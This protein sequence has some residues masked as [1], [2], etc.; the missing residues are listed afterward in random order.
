MR[1]MVVMGTRPEA[2]K[3][4]PVIA[5][6]Q[7]TTPAFQT[8]VVIT[9]QHERMLDQV[10]EVFAVRP[11]YDLRLMRNNQTLTEVAWKLLRRLD[12]ILVEVQPDL[13]LVQGDTITACLAGLASYYRRTPV[14]HVEAGLR[15]GDPYNP[16]PEEVNR[17]L[18]GVLASLHFAP[19]P[20]AVATLKGEG[21][22]EE[23][24]HLTGNTVVD[25]LL[26]ILTQKP[27]P[28]N[29]DD[30]GL[31]G[32]VLLVTAHRRENFGEPLR[33]ICQALHVLV[34][35]NPDVEVVF[36][37]H[38]NPNV[39]EIV[40]AVLGGKTRIHLLQPL[41]YVSFVHYMS[42]STLILTDS[43]GIQEEAPCL[44]K[45]VLILRHHTERPEVLEAG[46]GEL[47]GT[48][49]TTIVR[50]AQRLLDDPEKYGQMAK[51][52]NPFGDGRASERIVKVLLEHEIE[53]PSR[54]G[55]GLTT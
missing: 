42:R 21:V 47:V 7:H 18:L 40:F 52:T 3:L 1:V 37:V 54:S 50:A 35:R 2:I 23:R 12:P 39:R 31:R 53:R 6:L 45:P 38:L 26:T 20:R 44:G 33:A 4:C 14:A 13:V 15:T 17:R 28:K 19:T 25:A 55:H 10:L 27:P 32:R 22:P 5:R 29:L 11:D 24:I 8:T 36:P 46:V 30:L 49:T 34:D 43:G 51:V 9:H 48:D 41:D 16:F